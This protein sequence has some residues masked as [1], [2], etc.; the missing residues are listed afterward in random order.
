MKMDKYDLMH[1]LWNKVQSSEQNKRNTKRGYKE[2]I[3]EVNKYSNIESRANVIKAIE[4][5]YLIY[6]NNIWVLKTAGG[7]EDFLCGVPRSDEQNKDEYVLKYVLDNQ[8]VYEV[9]L[10]A[11]EEPLP[12]PEEKPINLDPKKRHELL[13]DAKK[14]GWT[15]P[16]YR[17]ISKMKKEE[18]E[19]LVEEGRKPLVNE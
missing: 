5:G 18:L 8:Y 2:F 9:L 7:A 3:E 17:E 11:L 16:L 4:K 19:E 15:G 12:E 10:A 1:E 13:A 14:L 6:S